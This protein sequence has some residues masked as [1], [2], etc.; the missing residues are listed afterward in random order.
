MVSGAG[1]RDGG[2]KGPCRKQVGYTSSNT[3]NVREVDSG[4]VLQ[5]WE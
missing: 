1:G 5:S 3:S 2:M 4:D